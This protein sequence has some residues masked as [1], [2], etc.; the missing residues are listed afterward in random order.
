MTY[1]TILLQYHSMYI[2]IQDF[3]PGP[4]TPGRNGG[5]GPKTVHVETDIPRIDTSFFLVASEKRR[6]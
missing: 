1:I 4:A 3:L 5:P 2:L 6:G